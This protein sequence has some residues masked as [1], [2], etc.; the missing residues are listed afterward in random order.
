MINLL[1]RG[2]TWLPGARLETPAEEAQPDDAVACRS[3]FSGAA[4]PQLEEPDGAAVLNS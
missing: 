2:I 1:E 4:A 3:K